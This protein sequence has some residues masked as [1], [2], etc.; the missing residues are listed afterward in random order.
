MSAVSLTCTYIA[1]QDDVV[2]FASGDNTAVNL[3]GYLA[4]A[5]LAILVQ[6][7][8]NKLWKSDISVISGIDMF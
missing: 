6:C 1:V 2:Y 3:L 7:L 5:I 4:L 8:L